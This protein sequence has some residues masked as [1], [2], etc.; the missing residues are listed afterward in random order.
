MLYRFKSQASADVIM[1]EGNAR[2]LLDIVGKSPSARGVITV[3]QM[4]AAIS[5]LEA[6]VAR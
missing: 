3:E 2:Q 4:P 1:L 6:A 5:A